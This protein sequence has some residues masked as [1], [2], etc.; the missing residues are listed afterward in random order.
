MKPDVFK[1]ELNHS[2]GGFG[3]QPFSGVFGVKPVSKITAAVQV[4]TVF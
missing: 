3:H 2:R 1:G 4:H